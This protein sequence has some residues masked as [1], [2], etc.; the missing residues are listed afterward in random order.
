LKEDPSLLINFERVLKQGMLTK[1]GGILGLYNYE[2]MAYLE[3]ASD[4]SSPCL[5]FGPKRKA[6]T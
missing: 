5:K 1:K 4:N 2:C 6:V 3:K